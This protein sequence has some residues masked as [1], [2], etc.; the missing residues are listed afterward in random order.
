[1]GMPLL[2]FQLDFP[3]LPQLKDGGLKPV[4]IN[5]NHEWV[6]CQKFFF[7]NVALYLEK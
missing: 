7:R 2:A 5:N 6:T 4:A 3:V 1:M